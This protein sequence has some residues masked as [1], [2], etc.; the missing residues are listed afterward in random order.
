MNKKSPDYADKFNLRVT[1]DNRLSKQE[2]GYRRNKTKKT[3]RMKISPRDIAE[4]S[5]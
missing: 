5:K 2:S 3:K 4:E 1:Q